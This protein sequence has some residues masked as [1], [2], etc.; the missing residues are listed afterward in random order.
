MREAVSVRR[1]MLNRGLTEA[2]TRGQTTKA[3]KYRAA[4]ASLPQILGLRVR[5][6]GEKIVLENASGAGM[7]P[8]LPN[9]NAIQNRGFEP[10]EVL[11]GIRELRATEPEGSW[12]TP[13]ARSEREAQSLAGWTDERGI[14]SDRI[15]P[16]KADDLTGGEHFVTIDEDSG[17]VFKSTLPGKFGFAVDL[18]MIHPSGWKAQSKITAGLSDATPDEYLLRMGWQNELFKDRVRVIG[19]VRYPQGLSVLST[20]PFY[21]GEK[22]AQPIIDAWFE[23]RGWQRLTSRDGAFYN[24]ELDLMIMDALPRNVLTLES[25]E[26]MPFDVVI[27]KPDEILKARFDL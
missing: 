7:V 27:V 6:E 3:E 1:E 18:E 19:A 4:I 8:V 11:S 21:A 23:A 26:L 22:T 13:Q 9:E 20:Q 17:L 24:K 5:E 2:I 16:P 12:I 15:I 14:L 10:A 25:G